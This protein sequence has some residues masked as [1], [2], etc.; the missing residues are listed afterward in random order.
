MRNFS[1]VS[2]SPKPAHSIT[3]ANP[4]GDMDGRNAH[5]EIVGF[6]SKISLEKREQFNQFTPGCYANVF[7][8][9]YIMAKFSM[10]D[11]QGW[12]IAGGGEATLR[13]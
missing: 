11:G 13:K 8:G 6:R 7:P 3:W 2:S 1:F 4:G 10:G 12:D 5:P 9:T